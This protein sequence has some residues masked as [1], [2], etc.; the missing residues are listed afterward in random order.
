MPRRSPGRIRPPPGPS[1]LAFA[2][3][4]STPDDL[5]RALEAL[6]QRLCGRLEAARR[7]GLGFVATFLR[8]DN[9]HRAITIGTALPVRDPQRIAKLLRDKL[10]KVDPGLGV[11]TMTLEATATTPLAPPQPGLPHATPPGPKEPA[12]ALAETVDDLAN[13]L[14]PARLWRVAPRESHVPERAVRHAPT[15]VPASPWPLGPT[16]ERP[17]RL[18]RRPE[19]IEVTAPL[20]DDPPLLFRWRG[21][22]HR[23]RA[24]RGPERIAAEWWRRSAPPLNRPETDLVRD[25]YQVEDTGGGRFWMFRAGL[26]SGDSTTRWFLHGLFG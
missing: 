9:V 16:P 15:L 12:T 19:P 7:G 1:D 22:H 10:E 4:I 3:P 21:A 5:S 11:E 20:P 25:Y 17:L 14:G 26:N 8:T 24:A 2:E 23:V 6:A 13:R 18:F